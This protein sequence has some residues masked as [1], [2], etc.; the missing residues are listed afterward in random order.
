[1]K[2]W[3]RLDRV[4]F[5]KQIFSLEHLQGQRTCMYKIFSLQLLEVPA[6]FSNIIRSNPKPFPD[7]VCTWM[8]FPSNSA[9]VV[10]MMLDL[11]RRYCLLTRSSV[12]PLESFHMR[13]YTVH[14]NSTKVLWRFCMKLALLGE[15]L[16]FFSEFWRLLSHHS[17][18][19]L[20]SF[21]SS[22]IFDFLW[23]FVDT[24][25]HWSTPKNFLVHTSGISG[26][27]V[28]HHQ[29]LK[30]RNKIATKN[31]PLEGT[32]GTSHFCRKNIG[33][34]INPHDAMAKRFPLQWVRP[35][36]GIGTFE[37]F[38]YLFI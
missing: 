38:W 22:C 24:E 33:N 2:S 25:Q 31:R 4:R 28:K 12:F 10:A 23:I 30:N 7:I 27:I 1:M 29:P 5:G 3:L 15:F 21:L 13:H 32:Q 17:V 34:A 6:K 36:L 37:S 19:S 11:H 9:H 18:H 20:V 8:G 16:A 35:Q 14:Q 26:S